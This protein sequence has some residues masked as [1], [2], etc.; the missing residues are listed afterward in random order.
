MVALVRQREFSLD[1]VKREGLCMY[2]IVVPCIA[3]LAILSHSPRKLVTQ[4]EGLVLR[5]KRGSREDEFCIHIFVVL[6]ERTKVP[7]IL[8][9][10]LT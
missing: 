1:S 4:D 6:T 5:V 7:W 8:E 3:S 9:A 2:G 10:C